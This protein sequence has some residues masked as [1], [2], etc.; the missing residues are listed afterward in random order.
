M[1]TTEPGRTIELTRTSWMTGAL[2]LALVLLMPV[3]LAHTAD[4]AARLRDQAVVANGFTT[5]ARLHAERPAAE[6]T[7]DEAVRHLDHSFNPEWAGRMIGAYQHKALGYSHSLV[8]DSAGELVYAVEEGEPATGDAAGWLV[9]ASM[10]ML[11]RVRLAEARRP[12]LKAFA[13]SG[14]T[15]ATPIAEWGIIRHEETAYI[16]NAVLVQPSAGEVLPRGPRAPVVIGAA[17]LTGALLSDLP[18]QF[19]LPDASIAPPGTPIARGRA[20]IAMD[21]PDGQAAA[22]LHWRPPRPGTDMLVRTMPPVIVLLTLMFGY[23][24]WAH[25]RNLRITRDLISSEMQA[26]H[27]A[28]HDTLTGLP[29]RLMLSH[30]L[31]AAI[32]GMDQHATPFAMHIIDLD[33]FKDINDSYGH[34]A[35]DE[36]ICKI[37]SQFTALCAPGATLARIGGDEFAIIQPGA[38][39]AEASAFAARLIE[40]A[41]E[42]IHLSAGRVFIG[43]SIGI[44]ILNKPGI[45]ASDVMRRA[46]LA[47]YRAKEDGRGRF[48]L[49][50]DDL[51]HNL[52]KRNEIR[53]ELRVA[54]ERNELTLLYQ[55]QIS[56]GEIRSVEA[57]VRWNHPVRGQISPAEFIPIAEET[58]L[59]DPLGFFTLRRAFEDSRRLPALDFAINVSAAQIRTPD[60]VSRLAALAE[61]T[62]IDPSRFELEITEG[63]LLGDDPQIRLRLTQIRRM[64]YRIALDDFGTGYSSLSYLQRYPITKIKID[65]SFIRNLGERAEADAVVAAIVHLSQAL[66]LEV[67]AEGVETEQQRVQLLA[68]GCS[69]L[70]GYLFGRPAPLEDII[71]RC[72]PLQAAAASRA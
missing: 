54:L 17:P 9:R 42:A 38:G 49:F 1:K 25:R 48:A 72:A 64:G 3:Y 51:E 27:L 43:A 66:N 36:L 44:V 24:F 21:A 46:D 34:G 45:T 18:G 15:L 11:A 52:R 58:G 30:R 70:Q 55:P 2:L 7:W 71:A 47:L 56:Q 13:Q 19:L 12:P 68:A 32:A 61:E 20:A 39:A 62:A 28:R 57:L 8:L 26:S 67:I 16:V 10:P 41:S 22:L 29:N 50:T 23:A 59:I 69:G 14:G 6:L 5:L 37:A 35:G 60:F 65:Q 4:T 53:D 33:R 40:A 31:E 63:L